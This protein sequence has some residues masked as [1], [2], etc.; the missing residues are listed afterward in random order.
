MIILFIIASLII[1][2][3]VLKVIDD[4]KKTAAIEA[5]RQRLID[6]YGIDI[7][8]ML[9]NHQYFIGMTEEQLVDSKGKPN[10]IETEVLKTKSKATY[11]YGNKSSGDYFVFENGKATK[12][13][14]R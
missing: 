2:F 7:A 4:K 1:L 5:E 8:T 9:L 3:I 10:K 13:V 11:I 14:D 6:K 12:I